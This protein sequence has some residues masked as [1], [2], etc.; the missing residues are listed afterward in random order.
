MKL[1]SIRHGGT[2]CFEYEGKTRKIAAHISQAEADGIV[3][4]LK[5]KGLLR[6][7]NFTNNTINVGW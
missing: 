3:Q 5:D 2:I 4:R 1:P 7:I 6:V